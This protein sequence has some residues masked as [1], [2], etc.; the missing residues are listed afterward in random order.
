M[1]KIRSGI[2][3]NVVLLVLIIILFVVGTGLL[4]NHLVQSKTTYRFSP[5]YITIISI[6][7]F[8]GIGVL[9]GLSA[10]RRTAGALQMDFPRL[11]LLALPSLIVSLSYVWAYLRLFDFYPPIYSYIATNPYLVTVSCIILGHSLITGFQ[12]R[13]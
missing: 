12:R 10:N 7:F 11:L 1:N 6:A 9:L 3:K 13:L 4:E 2:L 5:G 8:G